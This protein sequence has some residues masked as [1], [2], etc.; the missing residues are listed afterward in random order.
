VLN[1]VLGGQLANRVV[2]RVAPA[3]TLEK[4]ANLAD[5]LAGYEKG[6]AADERPSMLIENERV[7]RVDRR[8]SA[9]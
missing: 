9:S 6:L 8:L 3:P 1:S 4:R 2:A 5:S 7:I